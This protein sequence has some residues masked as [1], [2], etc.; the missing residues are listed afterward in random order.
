MSF[1]DTT[2]IAAGSADVWIDIV[3]TNREAIL[4]E[5]HD[6]AASAAALRDAVEQSDWPAVRAALE[7][8]ATARRDIVS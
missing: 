7:V 1:R 3:R 6:F 2:R 5:L 8:G 4:A